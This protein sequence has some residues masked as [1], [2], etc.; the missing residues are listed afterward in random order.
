MDER[1][2]EQRQCE[3]SGSA[4]RGAFREWRGPRPV[5]GYQRDIMAWIYE[6]VRLWECWKAACE[7]KEDNPYA[8]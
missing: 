5:S 3:L 4:S 7:W 6:D 8:D 1:S 2:E